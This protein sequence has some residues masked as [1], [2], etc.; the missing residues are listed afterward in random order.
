MNRRTNKKDGITGKETAGIYAY[1]SGTAT[2]SKRIRR[3]KNKNKNGDT[4]RNKMKRKKKMISPQKKIYSFFLFHS[5]G[6]VERDL[7]PN[8]SL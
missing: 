1:K 3:K 5:H 7:K 4:K 6:S 2:D 8:P